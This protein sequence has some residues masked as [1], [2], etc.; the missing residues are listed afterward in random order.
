MIGIKFYEP[1]HVIRGLAYDARHE[2]VAVTNGQMTRVH[3]VDMLRTIELK[4]SIRYLSSLS[5]SHGGSFLAGGGDDLVII[6]RV[7][8][9]LQT[10]NRR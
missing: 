2:L 3:T 6:W 5:F 10:T 1:R 7:E 9:P 8:P 4:T